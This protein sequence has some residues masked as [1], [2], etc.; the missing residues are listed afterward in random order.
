M[1]PRRQLVPAVGF[2]EL[3][4][5]AVEVAHRF[6]ARLG[7]CDVD[8]PAR[9]AQPLPFEVL[10]GSAEPHLV[11]IRI[12]SG[13]GPAARLV[14]VGPVLH[15]VLLGHPRRAGIADIIVAQDIFDFLRRLAID[16]EPAPYLGLMRRA[17][18]PARD[19]ARPPRAS[20][21]RSRKVVTSP[22]YSWKGGATGSQVPQ[23]EPL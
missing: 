10:L 18:L 14:G 20:R 11:G 17:R 16:E 19:P 21:I 3:G 6:L 23:T 12:A 9:E 7:F 4:P 15:V 1:A 2:H 5:A 13:D 22:R 8:H